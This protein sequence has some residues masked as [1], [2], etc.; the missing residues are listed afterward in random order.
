MN[1]N[2]KLQTTGKLTELIDINFG[3]ITIDNL[4]KYVVIKYNENRI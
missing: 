1:N 2:S 3:N 4:C